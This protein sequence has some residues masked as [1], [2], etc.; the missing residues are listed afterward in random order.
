MNVTS[1]EKLKLM[2]IVAAGIEANSANEDWSAEFVCG[3]ADAIV[4]A[5]IVR[6]E[7]TEEDDE[8]S[9]IDDASQHVKEIV[10]HYPEGVARKVVVKQLRERLD[11]GLATAYRI[12]HRVELI[13]N[14]VCE[15]ENGVVKLIAV[16]G[17]SS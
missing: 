9:I 14:V 17:V 10:G 5:L 4:E 6:I 13:S 1:N 2:A 12:Y 11:V 7:E 3:R 8:D 16:E 15:D